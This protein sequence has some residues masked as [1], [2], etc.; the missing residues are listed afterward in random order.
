MTDLSIYGGNNRK[1]PNTATTGVLSYN[2][3]G[4]V[5]TIA[6]GE[7]YKIGTI[8]AG[9]LVT[10]VDVVVT[11]AFNGTTPTVDLGS[12]EGGND[13]GTA[14]DISSVAVV[15]GTSTGLYFESA[16]PIYATPTLISCTAG[17]CKVVVQFVETDTT[18]AEFTA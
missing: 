7:S 15:A 1:N 13:L 6:S 17:S 9:S 18:L 16:M 5:G 11:T 10:A 14:L 8:P 2:L 3:V 4:D 12:I